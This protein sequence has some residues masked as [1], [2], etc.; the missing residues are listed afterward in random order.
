MKWSHM[1]VSLFSTTSSLTVQ[2]ES[3]WSFEM[4]FSYDLLHL[5]HSSPQPR[6]AVDKLKVYREHV[7]RV[8]VFQWDFSQSHHETKPEWNSSQYQIF[9]GLLIRHQSW[10]VLKTTFQR[11]ILEAIKGFLLLGP[12]PENLA[13]A[14][15]ALGWWDSVG[16]ESFG[17]SIWKLPKVYSLGLCFLTRFFSFFSLQNCLSQYPL[18]EVV[19][20]TIVAK[21]ILLTNLQQIFFW[22][23][24][25]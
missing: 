22:M 4:C 17:A 10:S 20:L 2:T 11:K 8:G 12:G 25:L 9:S 24:V 1:F 18:V 6:L 15:Q 19:K 21:P 7:E 5:T 3:I 23:F 16:T 13:K 14:S